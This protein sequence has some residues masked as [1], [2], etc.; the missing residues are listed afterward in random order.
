ML[1]TRA[2]SSVFLISFGAME[3]FMRRGSTA[4]SLAPQA[5]DRGT[6]LL[7][8]V[9]YGLAIFSLSTDAPG[10]LW[11]AWFRWLGVLVSAAGFGLRVWAMRTLG[12]YYTRT[13]LTVPHQQ[14]VRRGAYRC[15]RH[16]GYLS[17]M[18]IWVGAS[19]G[20]GGVTATVAV[21]VLLAIA[22]AYR[23]V[24]EERML[25]DALGA[26]Y[27]TYRQRSWRLIPFVY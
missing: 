7:I 23:I 2:I 6:T 19:I 11:P 15:I 12:A 18:M 25:V 21:S 27:D 20:S 26:D 13:L 3:L 24:I 4:K 17:A 22:Y 16:P 5:S 1:N 9:A 10:P 14:V 8:A